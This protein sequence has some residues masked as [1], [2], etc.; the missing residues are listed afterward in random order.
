[1]YLCVVIAGIL[2]LCPIA[3]SGKVICVR[4]YCYYYYQCTDLSKTCH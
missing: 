2:D 1:M 4:V 3:I